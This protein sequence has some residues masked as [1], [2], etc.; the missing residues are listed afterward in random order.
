MPL[1]TAITKGGF[2]QGPTGTIVFVSVGVILVILAAI[3][4]ILLLSRRRKQGE[5]EAE[6]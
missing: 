5:E 6:I 3:V 4:I 2:L 1:P